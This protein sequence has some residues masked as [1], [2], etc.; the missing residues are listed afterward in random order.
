VIYLDT[1]AVVWLYQKDRDRFTAHGQALIDSEELLISPIVELEIEYLFEIEKVRE[2]SSVVLDY[3]RAQIGLKIPES[4]FID[5]IRKAGTMKWTRDPF[6]R[7]IT[8]TAALQ[9][10]P[11]MTKDRTIHT[12]YPKA[13]W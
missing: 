2:R 6:D 12:H 7:I 10:L 11:L 3:L 8:A 4:S 1:H 13:V 9:N 5:I